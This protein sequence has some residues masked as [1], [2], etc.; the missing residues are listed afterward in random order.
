[1]NAT[2]TG[3]GTATVRLPNPMVLM[4]WLTV[5]VPGHLYLWAVERAFAGLVLFAAVFLSLAQTAPW[6]TRRPSQRALAFVF[7]IQF[8][9]AVSY[10]YSTAFNGIETGMRDAFEMLR[11]V[12]VGGFAFYVIRHADASVRDA[13]ERALSVIPY[14]SLF[15][16]ACFS[17]SVP[18]LT[19]LFKDFLYAQTKTSVGATTGQFRVAAPYANPNYLGYACALG[20]A[21][22]LFF[23][24][25]RLRFL[26]AGAMLVA[27]FSTGSRTAWIA[28]GVILAYAAA[29]YAYQGL[30][31]VRL[32]YALQLSLG[33]FV[34]VVAGVRLSGRIMENPRVRRVVT[35]VHRGGLQE[36]SNAS[37]RLD[38]FRDALSY[39]ERSPVLGWGPSKYE[40]MTYVD[41]QYLLW[42]LRNGALG[43]AVILA[44][45]AM[46]G[47]RLV[48][49]TRGD[50]L[51]MAGALAFLSA[52]ALMLMTG[53]FLDN[54]RLLF[55]TGF[56]AV[57]IHQRRA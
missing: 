26:H 14:Y 32:R 46:A 34:L 7:L 25:S 10:V 3:F 11:Y 23:G 27:I 36:E 15:V 12:I 6:E 33:L 49:S 38:Q 2:R 1:M 47:W 37:K 43:T 17:R 16:L 28:T 50:P 21:Y 40:T 9:Y 5:F 18:V 42:L 41:N 53:Q 48:V 54:F 39:I 51:A 57:A 4:V 22:F 56:I 45:L 24:R 29:A 19:G 20:L 13:V 52:L 55:L 35:A 30:V 8:L 31:R 44:A